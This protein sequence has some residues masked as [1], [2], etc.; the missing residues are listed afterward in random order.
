MIK[1]ALLGMVGALA[2]S[3]VLAAPQQTT[4]APSYTFAL[5]QPDIFN[6]I[7]GATLMD[8]LP[9]RSFLDGTRLPFSTPLGRMGTAPLDF[10]SIAFVQLA[11]VKTKPSRSHQTDGKDFAADGKDPQGEI[12]LSQSSPVYIGGEVGMFYGAWSGKYS[13]DV[14]GTHILG[15]VGND[16]FQLSVGASYQEWNSQAPRGRR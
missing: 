11:E 10:P 15:T 2:L 9:V 8:R 4:P 1:R 3:S 6:T 13:G 7:D 14:M 16:K 12:T 5:F